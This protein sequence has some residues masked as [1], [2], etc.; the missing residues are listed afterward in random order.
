MMRNSNMTTM[1]PAIGAVFEGNTLATA[2]SICTATLV[3]CN[4][5]ITARHC[6]S[7]RDSEGVDYWIHFQHAGMFMV[8]KAGIEVYCDRPGCTSQTDQYNDIALLPL[9]QQVRDMHPI[10]L[11][12]NCDWAA[13][14]SAEGKN[15][16]EAVGF[17]VSSLSLEDYNL[18]RRARITLARCSI[19]PTD[20]RF[21]CY[22][23]GQDQPGACN[24]DSGGPL[25]SVDDNGDA[26]LIGVLTKTSPMCTSDQARYNN[27]TNTDF[28]PWVAER[29]QRSQNACTF[30]SSPFDELVTKPEQKLPFQAP[31]GEE[32]EYKEYRF[33]VTGNNDLLLVSL[34]YP[35][36]SSQSGSGN[37]FE[38]QLTKDSIDNIDAVD[39]SVVPDCFNKG[40]LVSICRMD[41]PPSGFWRAKVTSVEGEDYYQLVATKHKW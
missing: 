29:I 28:G 10:A 27:L 40:D 35:P 2:S 9:S 34:N 32:L 18:K 30:V 7:N 4:L 12:D 26:M 15:R 25:L 11:V 8:D 5:V 14:D 16:V 19:E 38:L 23:L 21:I 36:G 41:S 17:G 3:S 37:R 6:V 24:N 39:T 13:G 1:R 33:D 22:Q 31:N 20:E